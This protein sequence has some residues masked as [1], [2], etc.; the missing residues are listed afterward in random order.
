MTACS[1]YAG[2][3]ATR[4]GVGFEICVYADPVVEV[5]AGVGGRW[6]KVLPRLHNIAC[7]GEFSN[8]CSFVATFKIA[9][10][11][12]DAG[13]FPDDLPLSV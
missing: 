6:R 4:V 3:S 1:I 12:V 2:S 10:G 8:Q 7:V 5:C 9:S 11:P 13:G